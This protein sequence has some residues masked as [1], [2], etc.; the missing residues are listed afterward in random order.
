M[1]KCLFALVFVLTFAGNA[2]AQPCPPSYLAKD[3]ATIKSLLSVQVT[4]ILNRFSSMSYLCAQDWIPLGLMTQRM[5]FEFEY[6]ALLS[7]LQN[8]PDSP[9]AAKLAPRSKNFLRA[10]SSPAVLGLAGSTLAGA[11]QEVALANSEAVHNA[12]RDGST[13]V[14][15]CF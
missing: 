4:G 3:R 14:W 1:M 2:L 9:L 5:A 11:T 13:S 10:V 12:S 6:Q 15:R 7:Y 8:L